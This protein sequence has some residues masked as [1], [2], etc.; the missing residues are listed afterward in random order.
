M[1]EQ[2]LAFNFLE[3][4]HD[5]ESLSVA[6]INVLEDFGIADRLLAVTA[7]NASNNSTMLAPWKHTTTNTIQRQA[8]VLLG[9][10]LNVWLMH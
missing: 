6:F 7:D 3:G 8:S 10:K 9:I 2:L 1:E 5:D 4:E